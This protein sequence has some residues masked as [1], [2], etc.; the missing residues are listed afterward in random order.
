MRFGVK[1]IGLVVAEQQQRAA[2]EH[3]LETLDWLL[4]PSDDIAKAV[5]LL[6]AG[7]LGCRERRLECLE[8]AMNV[9]DDSDSTHR[10]K[11]AHVAGLSASPLKRAR[12]PEG[13]CWSA[14]SRARPSGVT[15]QTAA[16]TETEISRALCSSL[17]ACRKSCCSA[18]ATARR[19]SS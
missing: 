3:E 4:A 7:L 17:T 19:S 15:R 13:A 1:L 16:G 18:G 8:V 5:D 9:T 10:E 14:D 12:G 6:A 11:L 2:G